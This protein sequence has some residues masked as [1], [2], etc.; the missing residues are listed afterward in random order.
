MKPEGSSTRVL[1]L[2]RYSLR[3]QSLTCHPCGG[4]DP[5]CRRDFL[6]D[7]RVRDLSKTLRI[8]RVILIDAS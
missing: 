2:Q 5:G 6:M 8:V 3:P 1:D 7:S 4:R